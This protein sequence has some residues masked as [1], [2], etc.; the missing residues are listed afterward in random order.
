MNDYATWRTKGEAA[1]AIGV[2]TKT[3]ERLAAS[4]KLQQASRRS[5]RGGA[6]EVVYHPDDVARLAQERQPGPL[7]AFVV[8]GSTVPDH[9]NGHDTRL[10]RGPQQSALAIA[11]P[12]VPPGDDVLRLVFAAALRA[13]SE[14]SQTSQ[15]LFLTIAEASVVSGLPQADLRRLCYEGDL[16][17][18]MTGRGGIRIRRKD[19]EAL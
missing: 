5:T 16:P 18:R 8:P 19:L 4:G 13:V 1:A 3:I 12:S 6:N 14:T 10:N 7:A 9:G 15:A 17:H 2:A 11:T